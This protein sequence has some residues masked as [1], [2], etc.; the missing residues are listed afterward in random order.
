MMRIIDPATASTI[1]AQ[2]TAKART[3]K[4]LMFTVTEGVTDLL[5]TIFNGVAILGAAAVLI[6][7]I[8]S[9]F[10]GGAKAQ[11]VSESI[12]A[13]EAETARAKAEAARPI[14]RPSTKSL[15]D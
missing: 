2:A 1:D 5:L 11:F 7:A 14:A 15:S 12:R 9:A 13:N 10:A 6:G 3:V 8:G 4:V